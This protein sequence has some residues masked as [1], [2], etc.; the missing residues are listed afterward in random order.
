MTFPSTIRPAV[1][2]SLISKVSRLFNGTLADAV[3]E[4]FQNSRRAGA[5]AIYVAVYN[6]P[7]GTALSIYDDGRGIADPASL[8]TLG[9]SGWRPDIQHREDPA[10]MGMFS[11]AGRDVEVRSWSRAAGRGWAVHIPADGWEGE[12]A[13]D[14]APSGIVRGTEIQIMLPSAWEDQLKTP[15]AA[16][17][18]FFPLPVHFEGTE[19]AR[20]DFLADATRI[21][22][23]EGC[24]IGIFHNASHEDAQA[25]RINFHGLTVPCRL[26]VVSEVGQL[27]KWRVRVD[28]VDAPALQLVLPARKEMVENEALAR[29]RVAAETAIYRTIACEDSHRLPHTD[30]GR[31]SELGIALPEAAAMLHAWSPVTAD[32]FGRP[33]GAEIRSGAMLLMP[34]QE[35]DIEQG[36]ALALRKHSPLDARPVRAEPAFA[37]YRWYDA[38]PRLDACSFSAE[39]DGILYRYGQD[40]ALPCDVASG[41]VDAL[42][43]EIAIT[44]SADPSADAEIYSLP[45]PM[46]AC[47]NDTYSLDEAIILFDRHA[48]VQPGALADLIFASLFCASDDGDNDSWETQSTNF[49]WRAGD[50]ANTL[51]LGEDEALLARLRQ[52]IREHVQWIIPQGHS[53]TLTVDPKSV[54]LALVLEQA[55]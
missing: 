11:L 2:Q 30:W 17:A 7:S 3:H 47:N 44:P 15:L 26:P 51:L 9:D 35:A 36:L 16:A 20:A 41:G 21:E 49:E 5:S 32:N 19:L 54:T 40:M 33:A 1:G 34:D 48:D 25:P 53:L 6:L 23:W 43:V 14:I 18:R 37:G 46:L 10:G 13:L 31:A 4:I 55:A 12:R 52:A 27:F 45:L 39:R 38:L 28:I 22:E 50:I 8:L 29:L 24:R 42:C